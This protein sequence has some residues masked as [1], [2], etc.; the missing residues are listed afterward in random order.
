MAEPM[1]TNIVIDD[2]LMDSALEYSGLRTK[3]DVVEQAL[4]LL[5]QIKQQEK[6]RDIR[7]KVRWTGDQLAKP[8]S[9]QGPGRGADQP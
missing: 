7:G 9:E 1:R 4:R 8:A 5:V 6:L 3:K 2:E